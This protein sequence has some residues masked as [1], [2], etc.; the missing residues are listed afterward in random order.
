MLPVDMPGY[1]GPRVHSP[2]SSAPN[3]ISALTS[4]DEVDPSIAPILT[5]IFLEGS[6]GHTHLSTVPVQFGHLPTAPA[7][8]AAGKPLHGHHVPVFA[9]DVISYGWAV[10]GLNSG[11]FVSTI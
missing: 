11:H 9:S 5:T 2:P 3:A 1:C 10:Y 7:L 8:S 6:G 4:A